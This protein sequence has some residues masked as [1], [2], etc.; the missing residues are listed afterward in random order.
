MKELKIS[1]ADKANLSREQKLFNQLTEQI[2][3]LQQA[4][5]E[6]GVLLDKQLQYFVK[7][8]YPLVKAVVEL[9]IELVMQLNGFMT[10]SKGL[11]EQ[12]KEALRLLIIHQLQEV[13]RYQQDEPE[14]ELLEIFNALSE[15]TYQELTAQYLA[16]LRAAVNAEEEDIHPVKKD[17]IRKTRERILEEAR[18]KGVQ[19]LYR[20]LAK[21]F[22]PDLEQD[23]SRISQKEELMKQ[24]TI[25]KEQG[26]LLT[27][28]QLEL[29]WI[30]QEDRHPDK[31]TNEQL[32]LYNMTLQEQVKDLQAQ[33]QALF[34]HPHYEYLQSLAKSPQALPFIDWK[35]EKRNLE[36]LQI[37][38]QQIIAGL[39]QETKKAIK[40]VREVIKWN[41]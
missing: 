27:M 26:D 10:I 30:Q 13:F 15:V 37:G 33:I 39:S 32:R 19:Q 25:A 22:H 21:V 20:Q 29:S 2:T 1:Q 34:L 3:K 8:L 9:R 7:H 12:E 6:T 11:S 36:N 28:L 40:V 31:L 38:M 4:L 18:K 24:L 16:R 17:T 5:K 23:P 35:S 14:G 41:T